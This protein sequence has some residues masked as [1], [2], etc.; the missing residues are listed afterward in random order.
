MLLASVIGISVFADDEP[1]DAIEN[2]PVG[3]ASDSPFV[4]PEVGDG[5]VQSEENGNVAVFGSGYANMPE[6]ASLGE[7]FSYGIKV[8]GIG[9]SVVFMVLLILMAILYIFKL[10]AVSKKPAKPEP[11][12]KPA[13]PAA[14]AED[15]EETVVAIATAAIAASRGESDCG[16]KVLS[17]TKI[18]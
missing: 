12:V 17:I 7:R 9:M 4:A 2:D 3:V 16:F 15:D 14:K 11:A 1:A 8:V 18:Q 5:A 10:V 6:D 13:A